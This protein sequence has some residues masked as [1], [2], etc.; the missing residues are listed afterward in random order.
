ME[1]YVRRIKQS[2]KRKADIGF[3]VDVIRLFRPGIIKPTGT[4]LNNGTMLRSY[5]TIGWRNIIRNKGYAVSNIAGLALSMICAIFIF[6]LIQHHLSYDNFHANSDRIYRIVTELHRDE[7]DYRSSVP[8]PL[9]SFIRNEHT[10][11]EKIGRSYTETDAMITLRNGSE[12]IKFEEAEGIA[13]TEPEFFEIF[14]FPL[15]QG[16]MATSLVAPNT[17]IIT[18]SRARKYFG[19]KNPIGETFWLRNKIPFTVTGVLK[20]FPVNTD[21]E[22]G[23]FVSFSTLKTVVPWMADDTRGWQ[24]IR[25]GMKCYVRLHPDVKPTDVEAGVAPY[26]KRFRPT[27]KNVHVYKL[28]PMS[29]VH[30]NPRYDGKMEKRN[31]WILAVVG[32]FLIVTA[33]VN[34]INLATAQALKRSKEVGV[35]KVLG[36]MRGQLL[37]QFIFETGLITF[38]GIAVASIIAYVICP[39]IN[40]LFNTNLSINLF[41]D[42]DL[43]LFVAGLTVGVTLFAGYYPGLVLAGFKPVTALKG[44]LTQL[45]FKGFNTR[46]TL[47]ISQFAIS[48]VLIIGMIVIISQLQYAKHSDLGFSKDAIIMVPTGGDTSR[49]MTSA[50]KNEIGRMR[51]VEK[52]SLCY[53]PPASQD[54]WFNSI[55]FDNSTEEVDFPTSIKAADPDYIG[56]FDLELVAGRNLSPSDTVREMVVNEALVR[57]LGFTSPQEVLGRIISADGGDM[58]API[59]GVIKDFHDR[60]F[61]EEITPIL[62][63]TFSEDYAYYAIQLDLSDARMTIAA[64]EEEWTLQH[65]D[66]VFHFEFLDESIARFYQTEA[67]MLKLI[68]IFSFVAIFIGCLG[69]Y[70]LV[71]FMA[72]QKT[73]EVGIRKVLG[74]GIAD[75]LWIFGKEFSRLIVI[76]FLVAAPVGWWLMSTWLQEFRFQIEM[77]PWIFV[78]SIGSSFFIAAVTVGYQA[79]KTALMNP[80]HSL[81]T[82]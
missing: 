37:G 29:D 25:G 60:S 32:L 31:L 58:V 65:P 39:Y 79:T 8:S 42:P 10:F 63:T 43:I 50:I 1:V 44:K 6:V 46:R 67:T 24:G 40:L 15:V 53:A 68:Q 35:R 48:Q 26:V 51:G 36:G 5:F 9:G 18:E 76:A 19:D 47:I 78:L 12:V 61:Y 2:G 13:F 20:D 55:K 64:I 71:S 28:Q 82:E 45:N 52:V 27:S 81:R 57:K 41:S 17:A 72:A 56:L 4:T 34:F 38:F 30:F 73:K 54:D 77:G 70:G 75:I 59:V 80:I 66:E 49:L 16:N 11:A 74:G 33:C 7:I 69:L 14:D 22:P 3:I 62:L 23:V 21:I